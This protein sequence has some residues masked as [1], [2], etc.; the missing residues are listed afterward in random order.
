MEG[1]LGTVGT[2]WGFAIAFRHA[3][4]PKSPARRKI[5]DPEKWLRKL[6]LKLPDTTEKISWGHPNFRV[7]NRT[8]AVF[9]IYRE[10]PSIAIE[11]ELEEQSFLVEQ[12]GFYVT[13]Y[14]GKRGWVSAWVDVPAPYGLIEDLVVKAHARRARAR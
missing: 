14:V 10:R 13:P 8:F 5:R 7:A 9:E 11:A 2:D 12:F 3:G 6:C 1:R 4:L